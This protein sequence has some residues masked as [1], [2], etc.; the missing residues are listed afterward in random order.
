MLTLHDLY[1]NVYKAW[2]SAK[3]VDKETAEKGFGRE[4]SEVFVLG[5]NKEFIIGIEVSI[6]RQAW[7]SKKIDER[8]SSD[9]QRSSYDLSEEMT[10]HGRERTKDNEEREAAYAHFNGLLTVGMISIIRI[11]PVSTTAVNPSRAGEKLLHCF[12]T[13]DTTVLARSDFTPISIFKGTIFFPF[14]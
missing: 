1:S 2:M 3:R 5:A 6:L 10:L 4:L 9:N 8:N 14:A 7:I 11:M 12:V 13:T